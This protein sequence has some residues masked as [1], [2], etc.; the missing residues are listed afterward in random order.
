LVIDFQRLASE[1]AQIL[2]VVARRLAGERL[3]MVF[4][5]LAER[6]TA[7]PETGLPILCRGALSTDERARITSA[8]GVTITPPALASL[9]ES[10]WGNLLAAVERLRP[11]ADTWAND[12][13]PSLQSGRL[14]KSLERSWGRFLDQLPDDARNAMF[15]VAA[16]HDA[17]GNHTMEALETLGLSLS[18]LEPAERL[19]LGL[20]ARLA[21]GIDLRHPLVRSLVLTRT[22]WPPG[23]PRTWHLPWR[24][25]A[26]AVRGTWRWL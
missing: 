5:V 14:H 12:W 6:G 8:M 15:D 11:G 13:W 20:V 16:D 2:Q 23:F 18:S 3:A 22:R 19:G 25:T 24:Q 1:S 21:G 10:T 26:S 4:V 9:V 17:S 7:L